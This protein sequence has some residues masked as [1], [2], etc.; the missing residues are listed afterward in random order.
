MDKLSIVP[1]QTQRIGSMW[2]MSS[3]TIFVM[4]FHSAKKLYILLFALAERKGRHAFSHP[5]AYFSPA[6]QG[7]Q[8]RPIATRIVSA[9]E[10]VQSWALSFY[11]V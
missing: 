11:M 8:D 1:Q 3:L 9:T 6:G 2:I 5:E 4:P 10:T 7:G